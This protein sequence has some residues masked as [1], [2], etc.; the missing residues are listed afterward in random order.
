M[1]MSHDYE[2]AIEEGATDGQESGPRFS[3][4]ARRKISL[5]L[6]L[7]SWVAS[8]FE[9]F[10]VRL[11]LRLTVSATAAS[12]FASMRRQSMAPPTTP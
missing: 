12:S 1:G 9:S 7:E 5:G 11:A 8:R 4:G 3:A 2:V 10:R 6:G